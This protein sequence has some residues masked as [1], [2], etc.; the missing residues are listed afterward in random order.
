MTDVPAFAPAAIDV[1]GAV[2]LVLARRTGPATFRSYRIV[3]HQNVVTELRAICTATLAA[4]TERTPASYTDD[5][6]FDAST[7]YL[8]VPSSALVKHRPQGRRGH[9]ST[10]DTPAEP[11]Q[12]EVDPGARQ[13][14]ENASSLPELDASQL[15]SHSYAFYAAVVGNDPHHRVR[16][17]G[18][19]ESVQG[20]LVRKT[21]NVLW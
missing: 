14:L 10:D 13:A 4:L 7:R 19:V 9:R 12:V 11:P 5:L 16:L 20:R 21:H 17:R 8:L 15:S 18:Q 2:T 1:S 3:M 6:A